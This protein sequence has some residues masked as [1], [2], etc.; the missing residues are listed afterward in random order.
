MDE[1]QVDRSEPYTR[2][3]QTKNPLVSYTLLSG[4]ARMLPP[5]ISM[6]AWNGESG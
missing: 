3:T 2:N 5:R 6:L 4:R 1:C